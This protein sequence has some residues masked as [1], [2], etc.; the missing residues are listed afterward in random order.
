MQTLFLYKYA[1]TFHLGSV[2]KV[3]GN[4]ICKDNERYVKKQKK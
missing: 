2:V 3:R 4:C 1:P